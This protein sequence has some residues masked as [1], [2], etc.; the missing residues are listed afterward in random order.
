MTAL[1]EVALAMGG[2]ALWIA[3]LRGWWFFDGT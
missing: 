1:H 2:L 3:M